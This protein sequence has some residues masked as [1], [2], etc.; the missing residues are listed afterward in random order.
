[1]V[2]TDPNWQLFE[3]TEHIFIKEENVKLETLE[4][5]DAHEPL[6]LKKE[7][8]QTQ[9]LLDALGQ[10]VQGQRAIQTDAAAAASPLPQPQLA[11]APPFRPYDPAQ[12]TWTEW[13]RQFGFHLA[14]YRIQ[15]NERQPHLLSCVG[16]QMYRV[17][18]KLFPR[19]D[20][21]TLSYD[22]ILSA[23]DAYFKETVNVVAKRYTFFRT[24][25]TTGQTNREW[26][27]TFQGLTRDCA[28]ECECGLPYSD[29]MVRDAIAQNVSDVRIREQ[30]LKLVNPSLQQVIDILDRQD[31]LDFAQES[32]ATSPAVC[33]INRPAGR[34]AWP[35]KLPPRTSA[36]LPPRSKPGVPRKHTNA[37]LKSC[38]RCAT[39]HSREHCP[40]RQAICFFCNKKGHV[41]SVCQKKLRSDNHNHSRPF[42][43]LRNRTKDTQARGP[44]PIDIHVVNST[45]S[46]DTVSNSDCVRPTKSV[47]RRRRKSRQLASD[48]VPVSVQ[49]ARDSRSCRQQDNKLFVHLDF[50]GKVI[51]FQLDTGAAVSLLN[52][53]TYKQLGKPPLRAATVELTTYS[54]QNIPVLGQ[55]ILLATYKGQTKLVS[56]YVLRSSSA[57]NLFGLDLFQLFNLSI[58]NQVLSVNQTVPSDSVSRLCDEFADIFAPGLGC[59]KNYEAHLELKVNAQPK[60]F[61]ARNVPH[62]LR[63]EV[64]RTLNDLESQGVIEG[65]QASLWASPL[66]ILPKPSRKLRLCVDFKATVNP[67]LVIAT[68]P[69]PRP[70]DLFD[71]LCPG[72][73]FSK[74]DLAGVLANPSGRRIPARLGG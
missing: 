43:S 64:A 42:A 15:G 5:P 4:D 40:S 12:E 35:G 44:S 19:R 55:C 37:L 33:N 54:G 23:L 47:R 68:F 56:F 66:V 65:V 41:Q 51:P 10:L 26:V 38:P 22:E 46:S 29:T 3:E 21:A 74:L 6:Q 63:D 57:V 69:L 45:S 72:K 50:N 34:A 58:V 9:A 67:Q 16:V 36:Q 48:A 7:N 2:L 27:A 11:V 53:D 8:Q 70:E 13:S 17:I 24:K 31:T 1:M 49:I 28:F 39:R 73:Y 61:R 62:A 60:F 30:I 59:A 20:I 32:F 52:H 25:R 18:V 14:A 71:K